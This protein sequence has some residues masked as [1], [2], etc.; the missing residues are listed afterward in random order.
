L[1]G[2]RAGERQFR[3][4]T[5][6]PGPDSWL[7]LCLTLTLAI[8]Y[9]RRHQR[10]YFDRELDP[11]PTAGRSHSFNCGIKPVQGV[12]EPGARFLPLRPIISKLSPEIS[13]PFGWHFLHTSFRYAE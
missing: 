2:K 7:V 6:S 12:I 11:D 8:G 4:W 13:T 5:R 9:W 3:K 1:A 10:L